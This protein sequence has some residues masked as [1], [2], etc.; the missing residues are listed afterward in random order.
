LAQSPPSSDAFVNSGSPGTNYGDKITLDV[1]S[2]RTSLVA[3][4]LSELPTGP[5]VARATLR[6]YVD[7]VNA[8][9][10]FNVVAATSP[11]SEAAVTFST[12]PTLGATAAGPVAVAATSVND[13]VLID[14][15][16]LAQSW[17][18]GSV[19]N[20]GVALVLSG[21]S[22][23]FSFQSKEGA[24]P[25]ELEVVLNGPAG[26]QGP[27]GMQ[28]PMGPLGPQG[29]TGS[30][31]PAGPAGPQGPPGTGGVLKTGDTMTGTL[32]L[33][34]GDINLAT[35]PS[36]GAGGSI[37]KNGMPFLHDGGS[38]TNTFVGLGA[39]NLTMTGTVNT[40]VG[41]GALGHNT[42]GVTNTAMGVNA[43][44]NNAT[45]GDNTATGI[46]ALY[47]N[48][49]GFTNTALGTAAL[50]SNTSGSSNTAEG[51]SAL[52]LNT[53]GGSN[54]AVGF[55][56]G[57]NLTTGS[58]NID[59][60]NLGIAGEGGTIRIG[61]GQTAAYIAGVRNTTVADGFVVVVDSNGR[62]G[63][64]PGVTGPT[65]PQGPKGDKGDPGLPG[66]SSGFRFADANG[67]VIGP[68]L[69]VNKTILVLSGYPMAVGIGVNGVKQTP[70]SGAAAAGGGPVTQLRYATTDCSGSAYWGV[71]ED[72][73]AS[74]G[75]YQT[76]LYFVP[77]GAVGGEVTV[78]AY[79][80]F[81]SDGSPGPCQSY[82]SSFV[83]SASSQVVT[84]PMPAFSPP[85]HIE[86]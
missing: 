55:E 75:V 27:P 72:A 51:E 37:L 47:S 86:Q 40:A 8:A 68:V 38:N 61:D 82:G 30:S 1:Q 29:P 69:D 74:P 33:S 10:V 25:P 12:R 52:A 21:A 57:L 39:G 11:W 81:N 83:L 50:L 35:D 31:G 77:P 42:T 23:K 16:A 66:S 45:G 19:A 63:A 20:S 9:G 44:A 78:Q 65:G 28:G 24:H 17:L 5:T 62:L 53:T 76:G 73:V 18:S 58:N 71:S 84:V 56:A 6:L 36:T 4:D 67:Q 43:L 79:Q 85:I 48:T 46:N 60:G 14:V 26:P 64:T 22:G 80:D 13:F 59:I 3:F 2:A 32:T 70:S 15:T 49:A 41:Q 34:P 7:S 54:I